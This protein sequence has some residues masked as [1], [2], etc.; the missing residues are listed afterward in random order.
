MEV[1]LEMGMEEREG[2]RPGVKQ[3]R[4]VAVGE[5]GSDNTLDSQQETPLPHRP[6]KRART[7]SLLSDVPQEL[8][9]SPHYP[10]SVLGIYTKL[11]KIE[12]Q[13]SDQL[14]TLNSLRHFEAQDNLAISKTCEEF[15]KDI[16]NSQG[17]ME[18]RALRAEDAITLL[19]NAL[20]MEM[21]GNKVNRRAIQE[22]N[23]QTKLF[24]STLLDKMKERRAT[25]SVKP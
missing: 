16:H 20:L 12:Q 8:A 2:E 21:R 25:H 18:D 11:V 1:D 24:S 23:E 17:L 19:S 5:L 22:Q 7:G 3:K 13:Y 15:L 6:Q 4:T 9:P 10:H 14:S